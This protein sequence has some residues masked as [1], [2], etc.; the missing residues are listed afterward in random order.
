MFCFS[1]VVCV[2]VLLLFCCCEGVVYDV[3]VCGVAVAVALLC[4]VALCNK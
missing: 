3:V 2:V 1:I 4:V